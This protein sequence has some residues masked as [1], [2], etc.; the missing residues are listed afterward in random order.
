VAQPRKSRKSEACPAQPPWAK[1]GLGKPHF[2]HCERSEAIPGRPV[3]VWIA[4]S[5]LSFFLVLRR[6]SLRGLIR[7]T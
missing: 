2:R 7:S 3:E 4:S 5:G 6:D 1:T